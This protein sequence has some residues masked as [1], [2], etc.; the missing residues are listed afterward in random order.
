MKRKP[1]WH[2]VPVL[3]LLLVGVIPKGA[4]MEFSIDYVD[5][6]GSQYKWGKTLH[7]DGEIHEGDYDR[8]VSFLKANP[9]D[10][11]SAFSV[12]KVNST[13]GDVLETIRMAKAIKEGFG[14]VFVDGGTCAS[15][16]FFLYVFASTH[17]AVHDG[18]LG[19]HRPYYNPT[20][21]AKLSPTEA[22]AKYKEMDTQV[23][24]YL[25]DLRVPQHLVD[26]MFSTPSSDIYWLTDSDIVELGLTQ[27]WLSE[28]TT[29]KCG[30]GPGP[31]WVHCVNTFTFPESCKFFVKLFGGI[32]ET[33]PRWQAVILKCRQ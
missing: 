32:Q 11:M 5:V 28:L 18:H 8:F 4:T 20:Y 29:A 30:T 2:Y 33:D 23:R 15:S 10:A 31:E 6:P 14:R 1:S 21:F 3:L 27:P 24:A 26:T 19:I 17:M 22:E 7:L 12:I 9:V 13:G 16:C 25:H